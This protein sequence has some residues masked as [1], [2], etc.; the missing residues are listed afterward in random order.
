MA[1]TGIDYAAFRN[2]QCVAVASKENGLSAED[3]RELAEFLDGW[4]ASGY[5]I[6][7]MLVA[8][9]CAAHLKYLHTLPSF[10]AEFAAT[11][12]SL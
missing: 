2:G 8:E 6:R 4:R 1:M 10:R 5:E 11:C 3:E 9:A 7:E 12:T